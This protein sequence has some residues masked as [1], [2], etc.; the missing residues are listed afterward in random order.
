MYKYS[1]K[2]WQAQGGERIVTLEEID[3]EVEKPSIVC[4]EFSAEERQKLKN[5][6]IHLA[7]PAQ[8]VRRPAILAE[9]AWARWQAGEVD[10]E[11]SLA[12]IYLHTDGSSLI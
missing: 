11:A 12:P 2:G 1:K 5:E 6:N 8:S 4:G 7:S 9:L 10:D 3:A